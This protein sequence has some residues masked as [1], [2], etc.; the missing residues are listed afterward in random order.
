LLALVRS[1]V[2]RLRDL[3]KNKVG[4]QSQLD[5]ARQAVE[6]QAIAL[7]LRQQ[8][9]DEHAPRLAELEAAR[10]RAEALRDQAALELERCTVRAPYDGRIAE[11][12]VAPGQRVRSGDALV[13]L[14]STG[15]LF[16]RAQL[17]SRHLPVVRSALVNGDRLVASALLDGKR[18]QARLR[19]LAADA[20]DATGGV[21]GLF[22]LV[23]G[24]G[25]VLDQG[26]FV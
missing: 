7:A 5:T 4:A 25:Q 2:E 6:R 1:E 12:L 20:V 26:R 24:S 22:D 16:V 19:G 18:I 3:V 17:P 15:N 9:V 10:S 13:E 21:D 8:A 11:V 14:Y 23:D